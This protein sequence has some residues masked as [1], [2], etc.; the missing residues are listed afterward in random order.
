MRIRAALGVLAVFLFNVALGHGQPA[1]LAGAVIARSLNADPMFKY[2]LYVPRSLTAGAPV[3]VAVHGVSR[4]AA[5]YAELFAPIAE[6]QRTVLVAPLF[7]QHR[8]PDYQRLGRVGRGERADVMLDRVL[9]EVQQLTG[10]RT[11]KILLFG[12]SG[13]GQFAHR[14]M[15][16]FPERVERLVVGA[17]GWYTFPDPTLAYPT[18]IKP[19]AALPGVTFE[20]ARFL[21]VPSCVLVGAEDVGR[22]DNLNQTPEVNEQQ[23]TTRL[24]RGHRWIEAMKAG[25]AVRNLK[26]PYVFDVLPKG[27]H[28]FTQ[29]MR[30]SGLGPK[31]AGCLF[32]AILR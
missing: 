24:E 30:D 26:T 21:T 19:A 31:V 22:D 13:G 7:E 20:P 2:F 6:Q 18:G 32:G 29:N 9:A 28:S 25:A 12:Y 23:G 3:F 27:R 15:M 1:P 16:A 17:A 10:A 14:Y 5:P 8:F 4:S 11:G